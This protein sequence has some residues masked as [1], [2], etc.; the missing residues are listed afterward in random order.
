MHRDLMNLCA[1]LIMFSVVLW[2]INLTLPLPRPI[3]RM[4]VF[5]GAVVYIMYVLQFIGIIHK[6]L[7]AI[8]LI[9]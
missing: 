4:L 8:N 2:F 1:M 7:P 3:K 6:V 9:T 5:I